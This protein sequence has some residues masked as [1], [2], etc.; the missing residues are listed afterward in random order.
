MRWVHLL[1][2]SCKGVMKIKVGRHGTESQKTLRF[3]CV[4]AAVNRYISMFFCHA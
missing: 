3:G 4:I 2:F 1:Q